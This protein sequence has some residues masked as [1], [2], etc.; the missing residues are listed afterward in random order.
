MLPSDAAPLVCVLDTGVNEKHPLLIP[1]ADSPDMH[2][3]NPAW[4]TD[5]RNGHG[6]AMAGL[7][8]YGD[9]TEVLASALPIQLTHCIESVKITPSPGFHGDKRLYGAITRES[10]A[11]VEVEPNRQRVYGGVGYG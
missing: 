2:T 11:Q 6:T 8:A 1:V 10:I 3:Y 4:G 7:S 5:D 9:L